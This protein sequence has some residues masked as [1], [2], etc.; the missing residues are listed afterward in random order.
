[1]KHNEVN[2][3]HRPYRDFTDIARMKRVAA[4]AFARVPSHPLGGIEWMLFGPHGFRPN[5]IVRLWEDERGDVAG[6]VILSSA[7][8]FE[9]RVAPDHTGTP[10]EETIVRWGVEGIRAWRT[11]N[12]LDDRCVVECWAGDDPRAAILSRLGFI[13]GA[14]IGVVLTRPLD[15]A[16]AAPNVPDGW[17]IDG[18]HAAELIDSRAQ[19]QFEAF[20]PGSH[21]T[22]TTWRYLMNNAPGYEPDLD[23]IAISPA[24]EVCAAALI[25]LDEESRIGE[26]EPVGTRPQHQRKGLGKAILLRGVAKMRER[27]MRTA[28]VGTNAKNAAAIALYESVGFTI[29]NQVTKHELSEPHLAPSP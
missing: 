25:W 24:G 3:T 28:I 21:T 20:S 29:V 12:S 17:R 18:L 7:D 15:D 19:T 14:V 9:Y 27:G 11:A 5:D 13:A 22:P 2:Y 26:F 16:I 6:W 1:M 4:Q 8:A 10:L 23:N